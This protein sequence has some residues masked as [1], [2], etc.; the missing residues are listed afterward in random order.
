MSLLPLSDGV[1][2]G[3]AGDMNPANQQF[4]G[5]APQRGPARA[6]SPAAPRLRLAAA[7][8][9]RALSRVRRLLAECHR[10]QSHLTRR[11]LHP[12]VYSPDSGIAPQTYGEF[13]FR[14]PSALWHE[15]SAD[16]RAGGSPREPFSRAS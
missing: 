10:A 14:S 1:T 4:P 12:D 15:P 6:G 2:A 7:F 8:V 13:L 9:A 5:P 11:R 16:E 3:Q